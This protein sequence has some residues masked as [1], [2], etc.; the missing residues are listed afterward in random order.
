MKFKHDAA[1]RGIFVQRN[2]QNKYSL[3]ARKPFCVTFPRLA[4][5]DARFERDAQ[6]LFP[7]EDF[8]T[9][10][11]A[12]DFALQIKKVDPR[13]AGLPIWLCDYRWCKSSAKR[14]LQRIG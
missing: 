1:N 5:I 4:N 12:L 14:E 11:Q 2:L 9:F 7:S 13:I 8:K 6:V 3:K 10:K